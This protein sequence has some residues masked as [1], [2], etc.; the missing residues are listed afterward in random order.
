MG[1]RTSIAFALFPADLRC[2]DQTAEK[3]S[4]PE[5]SEQNVHIKRLLNDIREAISPLLP[6]EHPLLHVLSLPPAPSISPLHSFIGTLKEVLT[7]LRQRCAPIRDGEVDAELLKLDNP[8]PKEPSVFQSYIDDRRP[9]GRGAV[10]VSPIARF[11]V[12]SLRAILNIADRMKS[13]LHDFLL[14]SMTEEQLQALVMREAKLRERD[15]VI[16]LWSLHGQDIDRRGEEIIRDQWR[17]WCKET[18]DTDALSQEDRW[19]ARLLRSLAMPTAVSCVPPQNLIARDI[20]ITSTNENGLPPQF[21]FS[22]PSLYQLQD[23]LQ[24]S[25]I[26]AALRSLT[27]LPPP[28]SLPPASSV[29][30]SAQG[31]MQRIWTLLQA[32]LDVSVDTKPVTDS[33]L[34]LVNLADEVVRARR[35]VVESLDPSE[36][37]RLREAVNRTLQPSDPVFL[38]LQKRLMNALLE[39]IVAKESPNG[40]VQV[41]G[42]MKAGRGLPDRHAEKRMKLIID[43]EDLA[44]VR[45]MSPPKFTGLRH[46][47]KG[48]DDPVLSKAV[49]EAFGKLTRIVE[50]IENVWGDLV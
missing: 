50:W 3:L 49:D 6:P 39:G 32:E 5:P 2:H 21:F 28:S 18:E 44:N 35:L 24:A 36:E 14:G 31:F 33:S 19:K 40:G 43:D 41:P 42:N 29:Q 30:A 12:Q 11:T 10:N 47:I 23:Y 25:V 34:K 9:E 16:R 8:P 13:D 20:D 15:L 45:T 48:F 7:T 27:R 22:A 26:A 1:C 46:P 17:R 4:S 37:Q 38:L